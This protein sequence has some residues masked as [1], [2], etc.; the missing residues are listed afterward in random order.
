MREKFFKYLKEI[1][2]F[3]IV[4]TLFAN[5]VS[6]Y[7]S[8]SLL[9]STLVSPID[10]YAKEQLESYKEDKPI[11]VHFWATWCPVCKVEASNVDAMRD[12]YNVITVAV[13]SGDDTHIVEY[14]QKNNLAF[15]VFNDM[16]GTIARSYNIQVY[17]TTLIYDKESRLR[18]SEV[19]YTSSFG[20]WLRLWWAS[21]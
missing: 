17:P 14:L 13:N 10:L 18:F 6:W 15:N 11:L 16:D 9:Q 8:Q 4:M 20:L 1:V 2:V 3:I 7:K 19:G 21:L 12:E 5:I